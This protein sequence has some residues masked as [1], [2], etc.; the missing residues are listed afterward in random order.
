MIQHVLLMMIA[1]P[2]IW[3][4]APLIPLLRGLPRP[5][6]QH[7]VAP[8]F[9]SRIL[10]WIFHQLTAPKTAWVLYV[11]ASWI[12][13]VPNFYEAGLR[14]DTWHQ[15]EH[16]TF[17]FTGLLFWWPVI[18]PYPSKPRESQWILIPY[19]I[20]ADVANT[21]LAA[22]FTFSSRVIYPHYEQVPNV[23]GVSALDDQ[24]TAG[25]IMWVPGSI[26]FLVPVA[27]IGAKLLYGERKR[28]KVKAGTV[29]LPML[30]RSSESGLFTRFI[31]WRHARLVFQIPAFLISMLIIYDGLTG[32]QI[33]YLNFAGVVPWIHWRGLIVLSLLLMGNLFCMG[34][35][36][37]LPRRISKAFFLNK[38][39][40]PKW[41]R[42]KWIAITLLLIFFWA[43]EAF[44]L[45]SSPWITAWI[46]IT[47]FVAAFVIDGIFQGA[48]FCKHV[49]PI[50]Q[51]HFAQS[52]TSPTQIAVNDPEVCQSCTTKD[53]I[54]GRDGIPG[55]EMNLFQPR[56]EGNFD[57]TFCLDCIHACPHDN[58]GFQS[59]N[60]AQDLTH[61]PTRSD[62]GKF[63][64]RMDLAVM[65]MVLVFSAFANAAGMVGPVLELRDY[66]VKSTGISRVWI[67]TLEYLLAVVVVPVVIIGIATALSRWFS[68]ENESWHR[69]ASRYVFALIPI[70]FGMWLTHYTF[71]LLTTWKTIIPTTQRFVFDHGW[72]TLSAPDKMLAC[73]GVVGDWILR[74]ELVFLDL[75]L[76]LSLYVGFRIAQSRQ[77]TL[78]RTLKALLPWAILMLTLFVL[79]V[80]IIFQ[81]MEM[82]GSMTG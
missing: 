28:R 56:K 82:R 67:V 33:P 30:E 81:P 44:S 12:W 74:V 25:V 27:L 76:L 54:R 63:S 53:C 26:V 46:A 22:I 40:W 11:V 4:G 36:F 71:H 42:G 52:L 73:C 16:A 48:A 31:R 19:L 6:R 65:M 59:M 49:C 3:L 18:Q 37:M 55:C 78:T 62:I 15:I 29:S 24:A 77:V 50:G 21:M 51:F 20:L 9:H 14:S 69:T 5:I 80:W 43:Y 61:D 57:C 35:P 41:L 79:G 58:V 7:W 47:Y 64:Q 66:F 60:P 38:L 17:L 68:S 13:H 72:S 2:L 23:W 1:P 70:G 34:C 39:Q 32:A 8:L 75:G 45:W 10:N